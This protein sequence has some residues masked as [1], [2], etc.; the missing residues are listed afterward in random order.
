MTLKCTQSVQNAVYKHS[1]QIGY[2]KVGA[3]IVGT[4]T[5][6]NVPNNSTFTIYILLLFIN[7]RQLKIRR[8]K[9]RKYPKL[10]ASILHKL[11]TFLKVQKC[12][13][14]LNKLGTLF[15]FK[16]VQTF[17]TNYTHLMY[18][19]KIRLYQTRNFSAL[20]FLAIENA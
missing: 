9:I 6:Q 15:K 2:I 20:G 8:S 19:G 18:N 12:A 11:N 14:I 17:Y 7:I 16:N 1:T 13:S 5:L 3:K 4:M 10:F